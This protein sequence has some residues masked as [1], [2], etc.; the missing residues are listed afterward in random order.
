MINIL[1]IVNG[2]PD[3]GI[4]EQF[5]LLLKYLPKD[6]FKHY[7]IGYCHFDGPFVNKCREQGCECIFSDKLYS[8]LLS[9][10]VN[11]NIHI[12]HI[13]HGGGEQLYYTKLIHDFNI[14]IIEMLAC[15]RASLLPIEHLYKILYTTPYTYIH[16]DEE[17]KKKMLSIQYAIDMF[18][19]LYK[20]IKCEK[21]ENIIVGRLSRI[22]PDKRPDIIIELAKKSYKEFKNKIQFYIA[23]SIPQDF[24]A[25]IIYGKKFVKEVS[26]LSNMKYFGYIPYKYDFWPKLDVCINP[27]CEASF[28]IIYLEAMACGLPILTNDN[29]AAKY[30][31]ENAGLV[32]EDN[33]DE[34]YEGLKQLY[35]DHQLREKLGN[36]GLELIRG[37]YNLQN[38][39]DSHQKLYEECYEEFYE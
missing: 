12:V 34:M 37:K 28:E 30:V 11:K 2:W 36:R 16:N 13:W 27:V 4:L 19:P 1:H 35:Y 7:S 21:K 6:K 3:G 33:V 9:V 24:K 5:Y 22:V 39:L 17:H 14:P 38:N 10:L 8:N 32:T 25:H 23:G 20:E 29:S 18:N 15:P 31:V 26:E